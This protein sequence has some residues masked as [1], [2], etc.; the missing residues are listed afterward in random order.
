MEQN[1]LQKN[2]KI[3]IINCS[4]IKWS[5]LKVEQVEKEI[6][7]PSSHYC[8]FQDFKTQITSCLLKC[9]SL[10]LWSKSSGAVAS[11]FLLIFCWWWYWWWSPRLQFFWGR[12][13]LFL[14]NARSYFGTRLSI[15]KVSLLMEGAGQQDSKNDAKVEK[16]LCFTFRSVKA[17]SWWKPK[18]SKVLSQN[19][20]LQSLFDGPGLGIAECC[21]LSYYI[22]ICHI[23]YPK[24]K[25]ESEDLCIVKVWWR[26]NP[27]I[28]A[29]HSC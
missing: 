3:L 27:H 2:W 13:P 12:C 21:C 22:P 19:F 16:R 5:K 23:S 26:V 8:N 9:I 29:R 4:W 18:K 24:K 17:I 11:K 7:A 1:R 14:E 25:E 6:K 15:P 10:H 28:I 20:G